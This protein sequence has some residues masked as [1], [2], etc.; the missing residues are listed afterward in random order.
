[1]VNVEATQPAAP[2]HFIGHRV[3]IDGMTGV[4]LTLN[5]RRAVALKYNILNDK[6]TVKL[7]DGAWR[8]EGGGPEQSYLKMSAMK[9][10]AIKARET[11]VQMQQLDAGILSDRSDELKFGREVRK[12]LVVGETGAGKS[13]LVSALAGARLARKNG[14]VREG[15]GNV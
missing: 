11:V 10:D 3:R 9:L 6:Y 2:C 15:V 4:G 12:V 5:G 13:A 14:K 7:T 8:R 1:M